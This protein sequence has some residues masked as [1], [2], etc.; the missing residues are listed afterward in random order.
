[1]Q[2]NYPKYSTQAEM[3]AVLMADYTLDDAG[4][5]IKV[6][7]IGGMEYYCPNDEDWGCVIALDHEHKL[8]TDTGFFEMDDMEYPDSDYAIVYSDGQLMPRFEA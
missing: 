4:D 8:A 6:G 5:Y 7:D 3:Y 2:D 1:M